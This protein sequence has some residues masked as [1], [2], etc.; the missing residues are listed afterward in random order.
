MREGLN[1]EVNLKKI[2]EPVIIHQPYGFDGIVFDYE[3][4]AAFA[5]KVDSGF[6]Q[7]KIKMISKSIEFIEKFK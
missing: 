5:E 6:V 7:T 4:Q 3:Y 2:K 1:I